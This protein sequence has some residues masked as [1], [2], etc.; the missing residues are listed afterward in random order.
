MLFRDKLH[1]LPAAAQQFERAGDI[2]EAVRIYERLNDFERAAELLRRVGDE[3]RATDYFLRA[4]QTHAE[5]GHWVAAGDLVRTKIGRRD[6]ARKYYRHGWDVN[7]SEA[8]LCGQRLIDEHVLAEEW[9]DIRRLSIEA[10]TSRFP[11]PRSTDAGHFFNYV[12]SLGE[13]VPAVHADSYRDSARAVFA[14]HLRASPKGPHLAGQLF[15]NGNP[16]PPEVVRDAIFA[17]R[18]TADH[19][20]AVPEPPVFVNEGTVVAVVMAST[21]RDLIIATTTTV[22]CWRAAD[23]QVQTV[24][25]IGK[26]RRVLGLATDKHATAVCVLYGEGPDLYLRWIS[27]GHNGHFQQEGQIKYENVPGSG[28]TWYLKPTINSWSDVESI[29]VVTLVNPYG[30][31]SYRG[32]SLNACKPPFAG[33]KDLTYLLAEDRHGGLWIWDQIDLRFVS[34][35]HTESELIRPPWTPAVPPG[36][37]LTVPTVDLICGDRHLEIVGVDSDGVLHWAKVIAKQEDLNLKHHCGSRLDD[38]SAACLLGPNHIAAATTKGEIVWLNAANDGLTA[39]KRK[40]T[41]S[42]DSPVVALSALSQQVI[43]VLANGAVRRIKTP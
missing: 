36:S 14:S 10:D 41:L 15:G 9:D 38:Y 3:D 17:T 5:A 2:D 7:G 37:C 29:G 35:T 26:R 25:P 16:W 19:T 39:H 21:S 12:L 1:D 30:C 33:K 32:T 11:P 42:E 40:T 23:G 20:V 34:A 43:A 6:L 8:V 4:A 31:Y 13:L 28:S 18:R 22:K 24:L 27:L